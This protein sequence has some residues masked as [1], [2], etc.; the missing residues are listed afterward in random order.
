MTVYSSVTT[1]LL[2]GF[3]FFGCTPEENTTTLH[4]EPNNQEVGLER[5]SI[6]GTVIYTV[7]KPKHIE[8][9]DAGRRRELLNIDSTSDGMANT[10]VYLI[11][12]VPQNMIPD[13]ILETK[14]ITQEDFIFIP[15][16]IGIHSE[17]NI[18][19][20]NEDSANHNVRADSENPKNEFNVMVTPEYGQ[21][22][23]F[24]AQADNKPIRLSCAIHR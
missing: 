10:I 7:K 13:E 14:I 5:S 9:D 20:T 19:F 8:R 3:I 16:V 2:L 4:D 21:K 6:T 17:Q 22:K 12:R 11:P 1:L 23:I 24:N 15:S 18:E